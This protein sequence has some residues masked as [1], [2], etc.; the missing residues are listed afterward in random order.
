IMKSLQKNGF[1]PDIE[2][3]ITEM[4]TYSGEPAAQPFSGKSKYPFQ[5]EEDQAADLLK[6]YVFGLSLGIKKIFWAYGLL[7]GLRG[8]NGFFDHTGLIYD[9][10]NKNDR[11][12]LVKKSA[13]YTYKLMTE[14]LRNCDFDN[15]E[16]LAEG[17]NNVNAYRFPLKNRSKSVYVIWWDYFDEP[18]SR[19]RKTREFGLATRGPRLM[20]TD[21]VT[22]NQGKRNSRHGTAINGIVNLSLGKYPIIVEEL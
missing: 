10:R 11:G 9:G 20:I 17:L 8:D 16:I 13:Y 19:K 15:I 18:E 3:W 14:K 5:S 4:G 7:E 6:R 1:P 2:I 12:R 22:D 21:S